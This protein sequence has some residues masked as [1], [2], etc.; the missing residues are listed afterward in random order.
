MNV[1]IKQCLACSMMVLL[2][3]CSNVAADARGGGGFGGGRA[4]GGFGGGFG[5][6]RGNFDRGGFDG[7]GLDRGP[8]GGLDRG[9]FD[10]GDFDP[11]RGLDDRP[12]AFSSPYGGD[13]DTPFD[14]FGSSRFNDADRAQA[15][16]QVWNQ[17]GRSLATDGGFA[18]LSGNS[19]RNF[20]AP[21]DRAV[22]NRVSPA[23]NL[24]RAQDVRRDF[25]RYDAFHHNWWNRYPNAW[26]RNWWRDHDPYWAWNAA[27]WSEFAPW[28]GYGAGY[29]PIEYDYGDNIVYNGDTVYYGSQPAATVTEYYNQAENLA[30][31]TTS[32]STKQDWKS[33]GVF[34]LVQG[35]QTN[36]TVLFQLAVNKDGAIGGNYYNA[37]TDEVKPLSGAVDKK[38]MRAAW[39][40]QGA[41][42]VVYDTGFGNLLQPQSPILVHFGKSKTQQFT[43]V[44]MQKPAQ[45]STTS[46]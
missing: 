25:N 46:N 21:A 1:F 9:A 36:S 19:V 5:G 14:G 26:G 16:N 33:L 17:S 20:A 15:A 38:A 4:V 41:K 40:V 29:T 27:L 3:V 28:W 13:R 31:G 11:G 12:S 7:G 35:T 23:T 2:L 43:L 6:M 22:T 44:R 24:A 18:Q 45:A 30:T 39:I 34:S 10:R 37:L 32:R 42:D 8:V